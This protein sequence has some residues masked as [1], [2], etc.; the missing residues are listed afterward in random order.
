MFFCCIVAFSV[1]KVGGIVRR[2]SVFSMFNILVKL[3]EWM[4]LKI[5]FVLTFQDSARLKKAELSF[6]DQ[7]KHCACMCN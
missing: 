5:C 7:E 4:P 1:G 6:K 3:N 2:F